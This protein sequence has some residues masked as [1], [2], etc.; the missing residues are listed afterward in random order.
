MKTIFTIGKS[1]TA[2]ETLLLEIG[3]DYCAYAL[4]NREQKAF[5][6]INFVSF[7]ELEA[8]RQL[9]LLFKT[10]DRSA[11]TR[12]VVCAA[13]AH[14]L[15]V[16]QK[17][18]NED[19]SLLHLVYDT[20]LGQQLH[21]RVGEWQLVNSYA[22]PAGIDR[23]VRSWFPDAQYLH[24]YTPGLRIY[25]GFV[26]PDQVDIHFTIQHF[27][28]MVKKE[29]QVQLAQTYGYKTPL[30]VVYFLLKICYEFGLGQSSAFLIVSGLVDKDSALYQE[31][32][33]YFLNI[34][35]AQAPNY[36]LPENEHPHY[37]FTSLY[38][39]AACVS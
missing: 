23:L 16:P 33:H 11:V 25:N 18:F 30:D 20:A 10:I 21:D 26:A 34:H 14:A 17:Q 19:G 31:L 37:F 24:A 6:Q 1:A 13:Y 3:P 36:A 29:G 38:N 35:F 27:R 22:F 12:T 32:H 2:A 8:E 15:L 39:L 28:V 9:G 4:L 7:E 5:E